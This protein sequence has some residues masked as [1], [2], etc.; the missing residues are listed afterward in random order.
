MKAALKKKL[1]P[2]I[3]FRETPHRLALA[4]GVG[5]ALGVIPGT[6]AVVAAVVAALFRLNLP[7]MVSGALLTNPLTAPFVYVT[8]Y[9]L[10]HWLLGDW[11]PAGTISRILLGTAAGGLILAMSLGLIG[12]LLV[13]AI[14]NIIKFR[15]NP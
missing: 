7:L 2:L 1:K 12:Y 14:V 6:G 10:G 4:F 13:L 5:V 8:S 15:S 3:N 9:F 11:L